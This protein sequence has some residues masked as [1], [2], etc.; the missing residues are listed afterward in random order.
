MAG[1]ELRRGALPAECT[2]VLTARESREAA[3][4]LAPTVWTVETE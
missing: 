2:R 1:P 4:T 3:L